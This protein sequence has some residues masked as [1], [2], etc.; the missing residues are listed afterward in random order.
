MLKLVSLT[1]IMSSAVRDSITNAYGN[2][3]FHRQST[4]GTVQDYIISFERVE[5]DI[6]GVVDKTYDLFEELME[7]FK[8]T[9]VKARLVAKVNY[10]R[11][12]DAH[13]I[14]GKEDYHFA[15][16]S[17]EDVYDTKDF[18]ERHMCKITSRMDSFHHNGSR[19]II[20]QIKHIHI[21]LVVCSYSWKCHVLW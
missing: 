1:H 12:N 14:I 20:H 15:S 5:C 9:R 6:E 4:R 2:L 18:Y 8:D 21:Q 11:M 19:L 7:R 3:C 13:D 17:L 10:Q 16:Y